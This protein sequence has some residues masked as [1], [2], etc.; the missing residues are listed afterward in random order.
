VT[1]PSLQ[2]RTMQKMGIRKKILLGQLTSNGDCLFATTLARQIKTDYPGCHLTW[3]ISSLCRS[4]IDDNPYVDEVWEIPLTRNEDVVTAWMRFESEALNR[5]SLGDFDDIFLTQIAPGNLQNYDGTIRS[6]IFN[7]YPH[8]I[9][10]PVTPV[11][12]LSQAEVDNVRRFAEA[13]RLTCRTNVVLFECSPKSGQSSVTPEFALEVAHSLTQKIPDTCV[14]LSSNVPLNADDERIIDGSV[15]SLRE[16]AELTK[17]CTLLVGCSS[18]I[19]WLCTS[20]WANP[21]PMIQLINPRA[22]WFASFVH[23]YKYWG[24]PTDNIIE[25]TDHSVERLFQCIITVFTDG[26]STARPIFH[27]EIK[28]YFSGCK[29]IFCNFILHGEFLKAAHMTKMISKRHGLHPQI[30]LWCP[31]ELVKRLQTLFKNMFR[32]IFRYEDTI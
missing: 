7:A 17:H 12:R 32:Y 15:L 6:S 29:I 8:P 9:T 1:N 16:N 2:Y 19:S 23:D 5:K 22:I 11:M 13:H 21:L 27:Q 28:L 31:L 4:I 26:F 14:I 18:G 10:V 25:M 24:L 30:I 20:D 3:A